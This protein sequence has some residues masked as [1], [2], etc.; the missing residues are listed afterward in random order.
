MLKKYDLSYKKLSF[1][2]DTQQIVLSKYEISS[3]SRSLC[4]SKTTITLDLRL[5]KDS[6]SLDFK[7][8]TIKIAEKWKKDKEI[9]R[10]NPEMIL[11]ISFGSSFVLN[12]WILLC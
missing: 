1:N 9:Q 11:I 10:F 12:H 2:H 5:V 7:L 8:N 4:P 6:Y 3:N